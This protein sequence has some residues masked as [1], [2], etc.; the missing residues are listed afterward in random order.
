MARTSDRS[1]SLSFLLAGVCLH[2]RVDRKEGAIVI[3]L[4]LKQMNR[5]KQKT[6]VTAASRIDQ[7]KER[8]TR[9]G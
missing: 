1:L 7:K 5:D 6:V 8:R 9:V 4:P 2:Y 3:Q